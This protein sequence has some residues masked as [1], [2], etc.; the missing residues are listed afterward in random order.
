MLF[1]APIFVY[2]SSQ[3]LHMNMNVPDNFHLSGSS[4]VISAVHV[5]FLRFYPNL[6]QRLLNR[7]M[8]Q[9]DLGCTTEG[10]ERVV[11]VHNST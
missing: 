1:L 9:L 3:I 6:I 10:L 11:S 5:H 7:W 4:E 2:I 8:L